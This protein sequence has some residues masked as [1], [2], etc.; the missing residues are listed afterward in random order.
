MQSLGLTKYEIP[1][2]SRITKWLNDFGFPVT[3]SANVLSDQNYYNFV[4][5]GFQKLCSAAEIYPCV[6]DAAIFASND[7]DWPEELLI[8]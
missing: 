1:I 2:D 8:W 3:L 5:D 6:M 4:L 7:P